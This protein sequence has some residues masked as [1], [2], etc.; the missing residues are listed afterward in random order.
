MLFL[1]YLAI[2]KINAQFPINL[3]GFAFFKGL[4]CSAVQQLEGNGQRW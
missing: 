3:V 4:V 1:N 2:I